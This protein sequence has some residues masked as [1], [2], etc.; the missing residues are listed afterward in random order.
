MAFVT[1]TAELVLDLLLLSL[2]SSP[3]PSPILPLPP[4]S[5]PPPPVN[6]IWCDA[7]PGRAP[8]HLDPLWKQRGRHRSISL[9]RCP[10]SPGQTPRRIHQCLHRPTRQSAR[11]ALWRV[12]K[13]YSNR[14]FDLCQHETS[15]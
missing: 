7:V 10:P 1:L 3:S 11:Y 12:F 2:L 9:R 14:H 4:P 8:S 13:D 15:F 5:P 6:S